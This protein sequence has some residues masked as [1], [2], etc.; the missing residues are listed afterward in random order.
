MP[1]RASG[2]ARRTRRVRRPRPEHRIQ[3]IAVLV[4][5]GAVVLATLLLTAFG[6]ASAPA[7]RAAAPLRSVAASGLPVP[8]IV[9]T[10]GPLRIQLPIAQ[11]QVTAIGYHGAGDGALRLQPLGQR[12]NHGL[13]G[14]LRERLFGTDGDGLVW[15]QLGGGRG[16]PTSALDV[17]AAP[18]TDVFAPVDGTVVE[19]SDL[20]IDRRRLGVRVEVQPVNAPALV[21]S[22]S[23]LRPDPALT[24]G[25]TVVAAKT[26]LGAVIDLSH[27]ERQSLARYTQDAGNHVT[28]EV[29]P[30][31]TLSL[32]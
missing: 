22:V 20:I 11:N 4:L 14:R 25:A 21:V 15:Y 27:V 10:Q 24:V 31:A 13:L 1:P 30:A 32:P 7:G 9:A 28:I 29:R 6:S 17:G 26:R 23:R 12:G 2:S 18:R 8:Q 16:H 5:V 3:R 19:I